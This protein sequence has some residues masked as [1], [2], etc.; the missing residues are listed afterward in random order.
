LWRGRCETYFSAREKNEFRATRAKKVQIFVRKIRTFLCAY[1]PARANPS[2][3]A[4]PRS[5]RKFF[6]ENFFA[7][8][9][10]NLRK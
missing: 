8:F 1:A 6:R 4:L 2:A 7:N 9:Y 5:T 3:A 10:K